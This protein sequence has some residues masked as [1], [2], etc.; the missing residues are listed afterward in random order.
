MTIVPSGKSKSW[1]IKIRPFD[2]WCRVL[3]INGKSKRSNSKPSLE[4]LFFDQQFRRTIL[5][6][7]LPSIQAG[8]HQGLIPRE[9]NHCPDPE[10]ID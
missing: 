2:S 10:W 6:S 3:V 4:A 9:I 7:P 5:L 8:N 1:N